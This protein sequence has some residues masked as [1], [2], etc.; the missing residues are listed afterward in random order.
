MPRR[1]APPA[2]SIIEKKGQRHVYSFF[3][4]GQGW[5]FLGRASIV[6]IDFANVQ[7]PTAFL[8]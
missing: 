1:E 8:N 2:A 6:M 3:W 4:V 7:M 5:D